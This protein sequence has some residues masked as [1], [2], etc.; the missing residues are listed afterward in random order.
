[1]SLQPPPTVPLES[2]YHTC[3]S[4][5]P[6][7]CDLRRPCSALVVQH[8]RHKVPQPE[9]G[10]VG[11]AELQL[12]VLAA[13]RVR[14]GCRRI[15]SF[16]RSFAERQTSEV[17]SARE[18]GGREDGAYLPEEEVTQPA[19]A[20]RAHEEVERGAARARG[21]QLSG[22]VVFRDFAGGTIMEP[23]P[24]ARMYT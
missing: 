20:A 12:C 9:V 1:M 4:A 24:R 5:E 14:S 18:R 19:D 13:L 23:R 17:R 22:D 21:H 8:D 16:V 6:R 3:R 15:R 2:L 7:S 10:P 11:R